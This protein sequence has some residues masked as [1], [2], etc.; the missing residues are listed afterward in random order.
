[1]CGIAGVVAR[2]KRSVL[3]KCKK[4]LKLL[5]H[6][7]TLDPK[8]AR[9]GHCALGCVR[10]PIVERSTNEQP[11]LDGRNKT[12]AVLNGE[13][14]N[15]RAL[16]IDILGSEA[17]NQQ[18]DAQI[19]PAV[20]DGVNGYPDEFEGM[21]AIAS[22]NDQT[23]T[24]TLIRDRVGI[25]PLYYV[26]ADDSVA[27]ASEKKALAL[28]GYVDI[29]MVPP[30]TAIDI[31]NGVVVSKSTSSPM[32]S[33]FEYRS[34]D[35]AAKELK[36]V[37]VKAICRQ[38]PEDLPVAV[39]CSG[40]VDSAILLSVIAEHLEREGLRRNVRAYVGGLSSHSSDVI[41]A[42][43]L[44]ERI[45]V[46]LEVVE[47]KPESLLNE[48]AHVVRVTETFEPN[49][50]RNSLVS[51]AVFRK[52]AKDGFRVAMCGEGA[53]EL[54]FGYGDFLNCSS[55]EDGNALRDELM[56]DLHRTQLQ[57]VD[58]TSMEFAVETRVPYLDNQVV[59]LAGKLPLSAQVDRETKM[60]K[61]VLREAFKSVLPDIIQVRPKVT[62]SCGVGFGSLEDSGP[63]ENKARGL[64]GELE[65]NRIIEGVPHLAVKT[66]EMAL[67]VKYFIKAS[68]QVAPDYTSPAVASVEIK[69]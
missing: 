49:I 26:I 42:K 64:L 40:G 18:G 12:I 10:L 21:Y 45:G 63:I 16:P 20:L 24:L 30:G 67:Y 69:Q 17:L 50:I 27:F 47:I 15:W 43:H 2:D 59:V 44:C 56:R 48:I 5:Q 29:Q 66:Y 36:E 62:L 46:S 58:R 53:D 11:V 7:G 68:Y 28:N 4:L 65:F 41:A 60:T 39:L 22:Y 23:E 14:Y 34:G 19:I 35:I 54:F 9:I 57:R 3:R 1:M 55:D 51:R 32:E 31:C 25:K 38:I 33:S 13:L 6:R 37:V 8:A 52:I 61:I